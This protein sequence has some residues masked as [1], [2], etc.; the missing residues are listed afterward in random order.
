MEE[1][2]RELLREIRELQKEQLALLR[3][4]VLPP[5]LTFRFSLLGLFIAVAI[6][7]VVTAVM[8]LSAPN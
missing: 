3:R 7:A 8:V 5:W 2:V 1:D 4:S 6:V